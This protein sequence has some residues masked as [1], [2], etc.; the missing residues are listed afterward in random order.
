MNQLVLSIVMIVLANFE[1]NG[2]DGRM[3]I[4]LE[5]DFVQSTLGVSHTLKRKKLMKL[6]NK[7]KVHQM[8]MIKVSTPI[9]TLY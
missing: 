3:L 9:S 8:K 7:L 2:I 5:E 1:A 6:I 4:L